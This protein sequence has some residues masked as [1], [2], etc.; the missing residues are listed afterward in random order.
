MRAATALMVGG[1][2][3]GDRLPWWRFWL[4]PLQDGLSL[5]VWVAGLFGSRIVWR[6]RSYKLS[7]DGRL[8]AWNA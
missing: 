8:Q 5:L 6:G 7:R 2:V 3:L 4:L 1:S